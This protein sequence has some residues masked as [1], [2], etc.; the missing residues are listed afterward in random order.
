MERVESGEESRE[1]RERENMAPR[2]N[3]SLTRIMANI[4]IRSRCCT[5][6]QWLDFTPHHHPTEKEAQS[7]L[8]GVITVSVLKHV[9]RDAVQA[10]SGSLTHFTSVRTI[11][12]ITRPD[13]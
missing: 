4:N 10:E 3:A 6:A 11:R 13:R 5:S 2:E 1:R 12:E 8:A 9:I 7:V